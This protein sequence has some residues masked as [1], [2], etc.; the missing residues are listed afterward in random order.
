MFRKTLFFLLIFMITGCEG[1][2]SEEKIELTTKAEPPGGTYREDEL[3]LTVNLESNLPAIIYYSLDGSAPIPGR[4]NTY[5]GTSPVTGILINGDTV[6]RFFAET[7][8]GMRE[9][10]KNEVYIVDKSPYTFAIPPGGRFSDS[11]TV[12]IS[13]NEPATIYYTRGPSPD[14]PT[15]ENYDGTCSN[16]CRLSISCPGSQEE[17]KEVIKF[18]AIDETGIEEKTIHSETYIIDRKKPVTTVV[19]EG[20]QFDSRITVQLFTNEP[21]TI[22]YCVNGGEPSKK[23]EFYVENGGCTYRADNSAAIDISDHTILKFFSVDKVGNTEDIRTEIYRIGNSPMGILEPGPGLYNSLPFVLSV[24]SIPQPATFYYTLDGTDVNIGSSP[25]CNTPCTFTISSGESTLVKYIV[26]DG[27]NHDRQRTALYIIDVTPP[28]TTVDK[29][30]GDYTEPISVNISANESNV[31]VYYT[32][33]EGENACSGSSPP[34]SSF[35]KAQAPVRNINISKSGGLW[36]Y[37]VDLAGNEEGVKCVTYRIYGRF[38]ENFNNDTY[39]DR[40]RTDAQ[41]DYTSG[42]AKLPV[43]RPQVLKTIQGGTIIQDL[44]IYGNYLLGAGGGQGILIFDISIP[45]DPVFLGN[46]IPPFLVRNYTALTVYGKNI[47][48]GGNTTSSIYIDIFSVSS[49]RELLQTHPSP[50]TTY[51]EEFNP[52]ERV[53]KIEAQ[54]NYIFVALGDPNP[55]NPPISASSLLSLWTD[56]SSSISFSSQIDVSA[57]GHFTSFIIS[58]DFLFG[59]SVEK[60][61]KS[62]L[63]SDPGNFPSSPSGSSDFE[64]VIYDLYYIDGYLLVLIDAGNNAQL[65]VVDASDPVNLKKVNYS[66]IFS[67]E[68]PY[69]IKVS[70]S[71]AYITSSSSFLIYDVSTPFSPKK[72]VEMNNLPCIDIEIFENYAYC[73]RTNGQLVVLKI[74]TRSSFSKVLEKNLDGNIK[75]I[76]LSERGLMVAKTSG[77]E[78]LSFDLESRYSIPLSNVNDITFVGYLPDGKE[79]LIL[80]TADGYS[81]YEL[82][83][84]SPLLLTSVSL[85]N[86][87]SAHLLANL[88]FTAEDTRGC[89]IYDVSTF[90]NPV[91]LYTHSISED[92][93]VNVFAQGTDA[94]LLYNAYGVYFLGVENPQNPQIYGNYNTVGIP[95]SVWAFGNLMSVSDGPAGV[96]IIDFT[97]RSAP[98][99]KSTISSSYAREIHLQWQTAYLADSSGGLK[100]INLRYPESPV[101]DRTFN[102]SSASAVS[103][104]GEYVYL[105][106]GSRLYKISSLKPLTSYKSSAVIVSKNFNTTSL[107]VAKARLQFEGNV[108]QGTSVKFYLSNN[109]GESWIPVSYPGEFYNFPSANSNLVWKAELNSSDP[110]KTPEINSVTIYYYYK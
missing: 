77:G 68:N 16:S 92:R 97:S 84:T 47:I 66:S 39:I 32:F 21:A 28:E 67:A 8:D 51:S 7:P 49:P 63:I 50:V 18:F 98:S 79:G 35:S 19:P 88:L 58:G 40:E 23:F 73:A 89:R 27:I 74:G 102:A 54:N 12:T 3:P 57:Y 9:S 60:Y 34:F 91:T 38:T 70:G 61:I 110:R 81:L 15:P 10:V 72:L 43:D 94:F 36:F 6:L 104:D 41:I 45:D 80:F 22:Y 25:S 46:F 37:G 96:V 5:S 103:F 86:I 1:K 101:I 105:G 75:K 71:T 76:R 17:C 99:V 48:A 13:A 106:D 65:R 2:K 100:S 108:P 26:T 53:M 95:Q 83:G 30:E 42:I 62:V 69:K 52:G 64:G 4:D 82:S 14:D 29:A 56:F 55:Q 107:N 59:G 31:T 20:G 24:T 90:D 87:L 93:C 109:G 44:V 33:I 85:G 78:M 11:L